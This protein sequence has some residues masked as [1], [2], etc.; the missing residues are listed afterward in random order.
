MGTRPRAQ[1]SSISEKARL[2]DW[3]LRLDWIWETGDVWRPGAVAGRAGVQGC[4]GALACFVL[5]RP[6]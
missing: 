1:G 4:E 2:G 6:A 3:L 5:Y